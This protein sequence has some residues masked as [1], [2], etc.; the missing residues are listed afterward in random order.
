MN[1]VLRREIATESP[2][3]LFQS[4][5]GVSLHLLEWGSAN[6]RPV[7]MIHGMRGHAHWFTPVGPAVG[8]RFRA[9]ALDLRGHGESEHS[10]ASEPPTFVEDVVALPEAM[11]LEKPILMGHS[12]G[13]S[14]ALRA[15][16]Q[17]GDRIAGLVIVDSGLGPRGPMWQE[18]LSRLRLGLRR[19]RATAPPARRRTGERIYES[20]EEAIRRFKLRPGGTVAAPELLAHLAEHAIRELPDGRFTWRFDPRLRPGR[21]RGLRPLLRPELIR[22]P[23]VLVYGSESP[24]SQRSDPR[25]LPSR[26]RRAAW[27]ALEMIPDAHHHVFLDQPERF[28]TAL[29][30]HLLRIDR[31]AS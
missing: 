15:A 6:S 8:T 25:K 10:A 19:G 23:V 12:M 9:L 4:V 31:E 29:L 27:T 22:C 13:G 24:I 3:N 5:N 18:A 17:L 21:P 16:V 7:L 30:P 2:R 26:F 11:G 28:N 20:R 14:V 1:D